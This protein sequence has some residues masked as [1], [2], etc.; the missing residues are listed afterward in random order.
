MTGL[1]VP[2]LPRDFC[3]RPFRTL[4]VGEVPATFVMGCG[5]FRLAIPFQCC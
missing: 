4:V 2:G 5:V 1:Q 3:M